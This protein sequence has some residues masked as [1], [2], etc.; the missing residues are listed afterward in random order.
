MQAKKPKTVFDTFSIPL[1]YSTG[2][3]FCFLNV[4]WIHTALFLHYHP[5]I[6]AAMVSYLKHARVA[7]FVISSYRLFLSFRAFIS[8]CNYT[9]NLWIPL[10]C[11]C[12][13]LQCQPPNRSFYNHIVF[14]PNYNIFPICRES[15]LLQSVNLTL[16]TTL[17]LSSPR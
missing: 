3:W 1:L 12:Y 7:S 14:L 11:P 15:H 4:S 13:C 2:H 16:H 6:Q 17:V 5:L 10:P 9:V 8:V